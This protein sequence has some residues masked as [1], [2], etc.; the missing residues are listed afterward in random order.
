[1]KLDLF[2]A[3]QRIS[4]TLCKKNPQCLENLQLVFRQDGDSGKRRSL[5][6]PEPDVITSKMERFVLKWK[7][8]NMVE[9]TMFLHQTPQKQ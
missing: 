5:A 9:E 1:M 2:H 3:V 6:T 7:E 8:S 4:G